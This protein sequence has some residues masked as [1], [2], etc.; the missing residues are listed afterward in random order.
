MSKSSRVFHRCSPAIAA[1]NAKDSLIRSNG[2]AF[3]NF[4]NSADASKAAART[5]QR[6][7]FG[8]VLEVEHEALPFSSP[9][10]SQIR[11]LNLP[12]EMKRCREDL[13]AL[14]ERIGTVLG[15]VCFRYLTLSIK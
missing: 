12:T 14:F 2:H 8:N 1:N 13:V 11:V 4:E 7:I 15:K 9:R 6:F 3:V 5:D 10:K